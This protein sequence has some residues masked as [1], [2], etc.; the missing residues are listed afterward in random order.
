LLCGD[1]RLSDVLSLGVFV[2]DCSFSLMIFR[3]VCVRFLR[4]DEVCWL[5]F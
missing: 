2:R 1:V 4:L 3:C 5:W